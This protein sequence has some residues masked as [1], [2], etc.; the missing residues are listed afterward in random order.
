MNESGCQVL[1]TQKDQIFEIAAEKRLP[2]AQ[3]E[4]IDMSDGPEH[5]LDFGELQLFASQLRIV[6]VNLP[7]E[8]GSA[9]RLA[10]VRDGVSE[11]ERTGGSDDPKSGETVIDILGE[12]FSDSS[13]YD[14]CADP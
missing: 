12:D 6:L 14:H 7:D 5:F 9:P 11:V 3:V 2:A 4:K 8:A 10:H 1:A 13:D